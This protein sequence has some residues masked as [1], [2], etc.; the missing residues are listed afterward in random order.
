MT[1]GQI[2]IPFS[3]M[4][5]GLLLLAFLL[6]GVSVIFLT[7][8]AVNHVVEKELAQ[9]IIK[10]N[11]LSRM[12]AEMI[13]AG[14]AVLLENIAAEK[15]GMTATVKVFEKY[16]YENRR[17][18]NFDF[19]V[20]TSSSGIKTALFSPS[21]QLNE[22]F[23]E[24]LDSPPLSKSRWKIYEQDSKIALCYMVPVFDRVTGK[25]SMIIHG[26]FVLND[27]S[28]FYNEIADASRTSNIA[29]VYK[30]N[31]I[32]AVKSFNEAEMITIKEIVKLPRNS[33]LQEDFIF[34]SQI[35]PQQE[36]HDL[37]LYTFS[38]AGMIYSLSDLLR[39]DFLLVFIILAQITIG[40]SILF[41]KLITRPMENLI[42]YA[43]GLNHN[44]ADTPFETGYIKEIE[45]LGS[46]IR[47]G[48]VQLFKSREQ[49]KR[50]SD[51][52]VDGF[53]YQVK[54]STRNNNRNFLYI[55]AGIIKL[56]GLE[57]QQVYDDASSLYSMVYTEDKEFF[58]NKETEAINNQ[59]RLNIESRF[60]L[61][62]G[63][64]KW[65][66]INSTPQKEEDGSMLWDGI[67]IDI[68]ER[69]QNEEKQA[70]LTEQLHHSQKMDAIGQLAGGVA[71]DLNNA[72][73]GIIG[74]VELLKLDAGLSEKQNQFL[75]IILT[76]SERAGNLTR[77]LL[78]FSRKGTKTSTVVDCIKIIID[79]V[80]L[81]KHTLNKNISVTLENRADNTMVVGDDSLL[82]NAFMNMGINAADAMPHGGNLT[83]ILKNID[84]D[85]DY[86]KTSAFK[87]EPG[88]YL[89]ISIH[90]TGCGMSAEVAAR[91]FEPFFTTKEQGKGTGLGLAMVYGMVKEHNGAIT[92]YSKEGGGS[93]FRVYLPV[94]AGTMQSDIESEPAETGTGTVLIIDDEELIRITASSLLSSLGY[95]VIVAE[96]GTEGV[97]IFSENRDRINLIILDMIMP[98]KGG[99]ETFEDIRRIDKD[100]PV[101][102]SSGFTREN[103]MPVLNEHGISGFLNKPFRKSEL[104]EMI[105]GV[106]RTKRL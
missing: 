32:G 26:G 83:F 106:L 54:T 38:K 93:I 16:L 36:N 84:L 30:N 101:V 7:N 72:L 79:T 105:A 4:T 28:A 33:G 15:N 103:D 58:S 80:T 86:C 44:N 62:D 94:T 31:M 21:S 9:A 35:F 55:S 52:L 29:A 12:A 96:N 85:R 22:S 104:A 25:Q 77:Q 70:R 63:S 13:L 11:D 3:V 37:R 10:R 69:K 18:H 43:R 48:F 6:A 39:R 102:I 97:K 56:L 47:S 67:A 2:K 19:F 8:R 73:A 68:T 65:L 99:R 98:V 64:I 75:S 53:V 20:I 40:F 50:I 49:I 90:D 41:I 82:Q 91:I 60:I 57:P 24:K 76:A 66:M 42:T 17:Q 14:N 61:P 59:W 87:I 34:G 100:I 23:A 74:A 78:T 81:L 51:N 95:E 45:Q 5:I 27:N 88:E 89:E 92:A 46:H 71:H 1:P